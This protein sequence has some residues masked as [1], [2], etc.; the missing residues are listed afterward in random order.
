MSKLKGNTRHVHLIGI[1]G[2][3]VSWIAEI[4]LAKGYIVTGSDL[5]GSSITEGLTKKRC[6]NSYRTP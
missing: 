4:L 5:K 2:V 6:K 1:G 3:G